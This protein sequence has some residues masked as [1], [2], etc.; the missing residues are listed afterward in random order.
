MLR[1]DQTRA[2]P[3]IPKSV[4]QRRLFKEWQEKIWL[5]KKAYFYGLDPQYREMFRKIVAGMERAAL[6]GMIAHL[7]VG[8]YWI[9]LFTGSRS[10][11]EEFITAVFNGR[12]IVL[13]SWIFVKDLDPSKLTPGE[14]LR[15]LG[16]YDPHMHRKGVELE[17]IRTATKFTD[18]LK[19]V[20]RTWPWLKGDRLRLE[21]VCRQAEAALGARLARQLDGFCVPGGGPK[22]ITPRN[23]RSGEKAPDRIAL[24]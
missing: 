8:L 1:N 18:F 19:P 6:P 14:V 15:A 20:P 7:R 9:Y 23:R 21:R 10:K 16:L 12:I 2:L 24:W 17:Q 3:P 4:R 11:M 22:P 13:N 5:A